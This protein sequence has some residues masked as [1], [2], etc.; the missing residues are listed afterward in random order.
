MWKPGVVFQL[1]G[2]QPMLMKYWRASEAIVGHSTFL[3]DTDFAKEWVSL[4]SNQGIRRRHEMA[5]EH[6]HEVGDKGHGHSSRCINRLREIEGL[7][8]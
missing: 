5:S 7:D 8:L 6:F 4:I 1:A 3:D 2:W